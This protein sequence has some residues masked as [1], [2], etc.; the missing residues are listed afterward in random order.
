M[1]Y[2]SYTFKNK[3]VDR[4]NGGGKKKKSPRLGSRKDVKQKAAKIY[5]KE[6]SDK[7]EDAQVRENRGYR[8]VN[9][10]EAKMYLG[11]GAPNE[12]KSGYLSSGRRLLANRLNV[13]EAKKRKKA[14]KS[15]VK[16]LKK[17]SKQ[18]VK[19]ATKS[20]KAQERSKHKNYK[21]K[22]KTYKKKAVTKVKAEKI[23]GKKYIKSESQ[24]DSNIPL[25]SAKYTS[26]KK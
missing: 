1:D 20:N 26:K 2:N 18:D 17:S 3:V 4:L 9:E 6:I 21:K 7:A 16:K 8:D 25:M 23:A 22:L 11:G 15:E 19:N 13:T 10:K 24:R 5:S 14:I 12:L